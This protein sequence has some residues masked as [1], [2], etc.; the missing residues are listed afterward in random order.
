MWSYAHLSSPVREREA[1]MV[2]EMRSQ[3][4]VSLL[5]IYHAQTRKRRE[6]DRLASSPFEMYSPFCVDVAVKRFSH[7]K[8]TRGVKVPHYNIHINI[9]LMQ[10]RIHGLTNGYIINFSKAFDFICGSQTKHT[11]TSIY[12]NGS[13]WNEVQTRVYL[14]LDAL[15]A[16]ALVQPL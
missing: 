8:H 14:A 1:D 15:A 16:L 11:L 10:A 9:S 2:N 4:F 12:L 3:M 7:R 13:G 5:K 6:W